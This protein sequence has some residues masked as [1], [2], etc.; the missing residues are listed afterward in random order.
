[1]EEQTHEPPDQERINELVERPEGED[2]NQARR[3][4]QE[5]MTA[6]LAAD[7]E[8]APEEPEWIEE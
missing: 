4:R 7:V 1:M 8:R 5:L 6:Q 3:A 2:A